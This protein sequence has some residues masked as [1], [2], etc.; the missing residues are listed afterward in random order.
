[1]G[2][3]AVSPERDIRHYLFVLRRRKWAI[4]VVLGV[5][6]GPAVGLSLPQTP[7]Y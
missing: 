5:V 6:M 3:D 4:V 1:V 2:N 7:S